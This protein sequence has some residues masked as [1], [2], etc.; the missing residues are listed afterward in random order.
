MSDLKPKVLVL[1][2]DVLALELYSRELSSD[3]QVKT[4]ESVQETR[5]YLKDHALD[6]LI[7]E[8]AVNEDEGWALLKEFR[9]VESPPILIVCSVEDDRKAGF[10]Q[11]AEAFLV[12]PVLPAALHTLL[13]QII[14]KKLFQS[15]HRLERG[16]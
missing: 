10:C 13:D 4:S 16:S 12:K 14:A 15:D 3:Y 5:Q 7:I 2:D 6:V 11:G 8:P 9:S 1:D